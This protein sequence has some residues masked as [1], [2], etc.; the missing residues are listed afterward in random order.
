MVNFADRFT[1]PSPTE[2]AH[3]AFSKDPGLGSPNTT[4]NPPYRDGYEMP[5]YGILNIRG[6]GE[7]WNKDER[8]LS[9]VLAVENVLD[10]QYRPCFAEVIEAPGRSFSISLHYEF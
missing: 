9:L 5:G 4:D 3:Q 6:G 2:K 7:L 10:H 1:R 8:R